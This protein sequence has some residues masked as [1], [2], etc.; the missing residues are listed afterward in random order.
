MD[1]C[2][3]LRK[4]RVYARHG[5]FNSLRVCGEIV[6]RNGQPYCCYIEDDCWQ[7]I[8]SQELNVNDPVVFRSLQD[9]INS[10]AQN[11]C[12]RDGSAGNATL[13]SINHYIKIMR[14]A[15]IGNLTGQPGSDYLIMGPGEMGSF[16]GG[17]SVL[18]LR[19]LSNFGAVTAR[20]VNIKDSASRQASTINLISNELV[21]PEIF[22]NVFEE[23]VVVNVNNTLGG[24]I[25]NNTFLNETT[26]QSTGDIFY[27]QFDDNRAALQQVNIN[28][29]GDI[30]LLSALGNN[31]SVGVLSAEGKVES[32]TINSRGS[33]RINAE[34]GLDSS[35]ICG[36]NGNFAQISVNVPN[37]RI[38]NN[39]FDGN[40]ALLITLTG[41]T[42]DNNSITNNRPVTI[43][44]VGT[45]GNSMSDNL[46]SNN[47]G[48][49]NVNS[50]LGIINWVV[51]GNSGNVNLNI[52]A[53]TGLI[54]RTAFIGNQGSL[55]NTNNAPNTQNTI[56]IGNQT[57]PPTNF[58][59]TQ[60]YTFP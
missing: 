27:L 1:N 57:Q 17:Q 12:V 49:I 32:A 21:E 55:N 18:R 60:I 5:N 42:I 25:S 45:G 56:L 35:L 47:S 58:V 54:N 3:T 14:G 16:T 10:G 40:R 4:Q 51:N 19:Q 26:I 52:N 31:W 22:N 28:S 15:S 7:A 33:L 46:V 38:N 13:L 6:D 29:E 2:K 34:I 41:Q 37:G 11:I 24:R 20:N 36:V 39:H 50:E 44:Q 30:R 59:A 8:V 43:V 53:A 23:V 9:A 48:D